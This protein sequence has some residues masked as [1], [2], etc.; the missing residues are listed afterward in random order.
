MACP[1]A[2]A[3]ANDAAQFAELKTQGELTKRAWERGVQVGVF[4]LFCLNSVDVVRC[5]KH[6]VGSV[7]GLNAKPGALVRRAVD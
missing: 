3:D 4:F 7:A 2:S 6:L 5:A 1:H